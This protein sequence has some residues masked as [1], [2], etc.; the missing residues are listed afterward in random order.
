[1]HTPAEAPTAERGEYLAN[2]VANCAGCHPQ[3]NLLD[4]S[5]TGPRFSGGGVIPRETDPSQVYVTPNLT[6]DSATGHIY[7]WSEDQFV[8][9]F[10]AG[11]VFE[12]THMPWAAFGKMSDTDL[13]AIYR[14][15]RS[16][17]PVTNPTGAL[18]QPAKR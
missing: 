6:P 1:V 12:D 11:R 10:R 5:Y 7:R 4:G 8:A 2:R 16:L 9:R 18:I 15:L 3:R 14:Y 13:R 17:A